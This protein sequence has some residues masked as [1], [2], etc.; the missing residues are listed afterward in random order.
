M[1]SLTFFQILSLPIFLPPP[2][3]SFPFFQEVSL[4]ISPFVLYN[5]N[6]KS[7]DQLAL[8]LTSQERA[9]T[10]L[11]LITVLV[12]VEVKVKVW[13]NV[14]RELEVLEVLVMTGTRDSTET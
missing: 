6:M 5:F 1:S 12:P 9:E 4:A 10:I 14:N 13:E 2:S 3:L 11:S 8:I 7:W